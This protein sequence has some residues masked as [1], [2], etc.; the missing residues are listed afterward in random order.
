MG[1]AALF[2]DWRNLNWDVFDSN[3]GQLGLRCLGRPA[4]DFTPALTRRKRVALVGYQPRAERLV[5]GVE[6]GDSWRDDG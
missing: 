4:D 1:D 3:Q 2:G 5:A 6:G